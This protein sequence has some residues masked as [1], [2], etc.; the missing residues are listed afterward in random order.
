MTLDYFRHK[1]ESSDSESEKSDSDDQK[2]D[3]VAGGVY[4]PVATQ[5]ISAA[6]AGLT[7]SIALA[8]GIKGLLMP[9]KVGDENYALPPSLHSN[10]K[11]NEET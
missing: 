3:F 9:N 10:D 1:D 4:A 11:P 6:A 5:S 2:G 8:T 7:M